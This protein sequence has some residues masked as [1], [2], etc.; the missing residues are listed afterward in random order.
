MKPTWR[1]RATAALALGMLAL[2]GPS[3]AHAG[4]YEHVLADSAEGWSGTVQD[5]GSGYV[6]TGADPGVL[7]GHW[8]TPR[9]G[10]AHGESVLWTYT[11]PAALRIEG[12]G[13]RV[14]VSGVAG[15]FN[16]KF[17]ADGVGGNLTGSHAPSGNGTFGFTA[18]GL[19]AGWVDAT[20]VC[21]GPGA[22][23][24]TSATM[25]LQDVVVTLRDQADPA[26]ASVRGP[27]LDGGRKTGSP[28]LTLTASDV[29]GG[30]HTGTW[31]VDGVARA[32][33]VLNPNGGFCQDRDA[34]SGNQFARPAPCMPSVSTTLAFD[35]TTVADGAH[36]VQLLVSDAA[37]NTVPAFDPVSLTVDNVP[38]PANI[39]VPMVYG[40]AREGVLLT[41]TRGAWTG[42]GIAFA[43]R[44]QRQ[45]GGAWVDLPGATGDTLKLGAEDVGHR[46]RVLVRATSGEGSAEAASEPTATVVAESAASPGGDADGD[47]IR[48]ELDPDDDNDGVPD[49]VDPAPWDPRFPTGGSG[50][51]T[52]GA[53]NG[54]GTNTGGATNGGGGTSTSGGG[55]SAGGTAQIGPNGSNAS[56]RAVTTVS[57]ARTRTLRHGSRATLAGRLVDE[58]G[59]PIAGADLAVQERRY[60][61][62]VGHPTNA[63]W[64]A[65]GTVTTDAG[66]RFRFL[67]PAGASRTVRFAYKAFREASE[68]HSTRE[69]T[70]VVKGAAT[71]RAS[72]QSLRNGQSVTFTGRV[73]ATPVPRSGLVIELQ[74][75]TAR[76]WVTFKTTRTSRSG[77][78]STAYRFLSTTGRRTYAFRARI[79]PDSS[80]PYLA[81]TTRQVQV[82]VTGR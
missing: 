74:A 34:R 57:G 44:W 45:H 54:G 38:P 47:G 64:T 32:P 77:A 29:G 46:V 42:D 16:T 28:T 39:A 52:G 31:K 49:L 30:I 7:I 18:G 43:Y 4:S 15:D 79:K 20:L 40:S 2:A 37:G 78:F 80:W 14:T 81:A 1:R 13:A 67:A 26:I 59:R 22:C 23:V 76:G 66:G 53:T 8:G 5:L 82:T 55:A 75:R 12:W 61:P 17:R 56:I 19:N 21:G 63:I 10:L 65:A 58:A 73:T 6:F 69:V 48:N 25:L 11:A 51:N 50:T 24:S 72:R 60:V 36:T 41:A 70:L 71:L 27:L 62:R 68:F 9:S 33:F 35:T 3:P